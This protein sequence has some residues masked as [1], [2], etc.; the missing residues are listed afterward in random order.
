MGAGRAA[1]RR[2]SVI[3]VTHP[4]LAVRR[5]AFAVRLLQFLSGEGSQLEMSPMGVKITLLEATTSLLSKWGSWAPR[6]VS[7]HVG[8]LRT[9]FLRMREK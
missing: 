8:S 3:S 1:R 4:R 2:G 6:P 7:A 5:A 9:G